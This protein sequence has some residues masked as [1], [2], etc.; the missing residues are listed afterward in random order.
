MEKRHGDR[1]A[2]PS[3]PRDPFA[4]GRG[5]ERLAE[6]ERKRIVPTRAPEVSRKSVF[7]NIPYD[8][9]F[10]RLY[11]AYISGLT[12]FGL[13]P[14]ATVEI[15]GCRNRLDKIFELIRSCSYSIHD[16]SRVQLDRNPPATPRFN[17]PFELG[18][19][20]ASAKLDAHFDNWF[21]FESMPRRPQKSLSDLSGSDVYIHQGTVEGVMRELCNA[22]SREAPSERCSVSEMLRTYRAVSHLSEEVQRKTRARSLFEASVF[23][24]LYF[25]ASTAAGIPQTR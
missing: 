22:F 17:M 9:R 2:M 15:P 10:R 18:L 11:L 12:H 4:S 23:D 6:G 8:D 3:R 20:V 21:V 1:R 16:L 14:R 5:G 24:R 7:L 19:A 13:R 25:V